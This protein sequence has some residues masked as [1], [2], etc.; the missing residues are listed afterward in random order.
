[1]SRRRSPRDTPPIEDGNPH[2]TRV[3]AQAPSELGRSASSPEDEQWVEEMWTYC[4]HAGQPV[5]RSGLR[6]YLHLHRTR[7]QQGYPA[8]LT[9]MRRGYSDHRG[10]QVSRSVPVQP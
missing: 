10:G 1:M 9:I 6:R 2:D 4:R 7:R 8:I 3:L 5:S